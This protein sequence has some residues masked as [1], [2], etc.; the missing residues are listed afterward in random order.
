MPLVRIDIKRHPDPAHLPRLGQVDY[1]AMKR[2][3]NV[4]TMTTSRY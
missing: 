2:T 3:I 1:S 4:P